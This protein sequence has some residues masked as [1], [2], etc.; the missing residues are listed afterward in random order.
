MSSLF[1]APPGYLYLYPALLAL[2]PSAVTLALEVALE[3]ADVAIRVALGGYEHDLHAVV[4]EG[5]RARA[6]STQGGRGSVACAFVIR[7]PLARSDPRAPSGT[8]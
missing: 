6:T 7:I 3:F 2:E 5:A 4:R 1:S 8:S